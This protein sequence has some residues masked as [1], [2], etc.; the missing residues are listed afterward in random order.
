M[1][2]NTEFN[3]MGFEYNGYSAQAFQSIAGRQMNNVTA[4]SNSA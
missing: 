2:D 3:K 1:G 4:S